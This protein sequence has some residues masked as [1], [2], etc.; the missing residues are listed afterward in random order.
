MK[1]LDVFRFGLRAASGYPAR[2]LLMLLAMSI[3]VASVILLTTLGE[4]ARRYVT[5]EFTSLGTHLLIVLPGRSE[6]TGGPPPLLGETPRDLTLED[7]LALSRSSSVR[8]VAPIAL[9]SAP[10]AWKQ[11]DREVIILG[12]T[13]ELFDIR[14]L[15][16]AQG[17]FI[18]AGDPARAVAVCVLG[19]KIKNELFGNQS[20]L[21]KWVRIGQRRFRVI[22]ILTP[23]GQSMGANMSDVAVIPVASAQ[24]LF[25]TSS[26]FR[27]MVQARGRHAVADAKKAIL[28]I[29]RDR[30]EGEDDITVVT[31]DALL[32]TFDRIFTALTLTVAGIAAIS[33]VV[34]GILIMNVMLIAVSQRRTEIGLLKAIGATGGQIL[35]LFLSE[36]A[37]LSLIGA[38]FGIILALLGTWVIIRLYPNFPL[39]I[40]LWS[41]SAA[42]G[43]A[44]ITGLIF[45]VMPARRAAKLDPVEA[46]S[47]R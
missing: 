2:T 25:N 15:S 46:L 43:V 40:P 22:G 28:K 9:G 8:R 34:A 11:R 19:N 33:L 42:T 17:R 35:Q 18:P 23:K 41:L 31:Q 24:A 10:V 12:S 6:T 5:R 3:G 14:Q 1:V 32:A 45:G 21:G 30:H 26:L 27:I 29:I 44:L 4:G 13:A 38:L 16:M 39:M 36:S 7:A 47:R 37:I 20:P